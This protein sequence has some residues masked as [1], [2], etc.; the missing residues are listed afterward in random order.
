MK[1]NL[2]EVCEKLGYIF[3]TG[4]LLET[5]LTHRSYRL[6]NN[7]R[8]EFLGDA[9]LN[10]CIAEKLF[11]EYPSYNEGDLSRSRANLVNGEVLAALA[12]QL[13]INKHLRL[14]GGELKSGGLQRRSNLANAMEAIIGAIYLDGG[15]EACRQRIISWFCESFVTTSSRGAKKDPKTQ[16][17]EYT[18]AKK[19]TL[20]KYAIVS[21]KG[22]EH[23]QTFHVECIV[24]ELEHTAVGMGSSRCRAEQDAAEKL[25]ASM[26]VST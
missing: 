17:Q 5:A 1:K 3:Q 14:G 18:Q 6:K 20:P 7:E 26:G 22:R 12:K 19:M 11:Q 13:E 16:L 15:I 21:R 9:V 4:S 23:T 2:I 8:L 24:G 25:L 10:F